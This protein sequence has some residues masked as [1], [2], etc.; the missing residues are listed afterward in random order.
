MSGH[1]YPNPTHLQTK[2]YMRICLYKGYVSVWCLWHAP[3]Q[4]PYKNNM[5]VV[6]VCLF[7]LHIPNTTTYLPTHPPTHPHTY[8]PTKHHHHHHLPTYLLN[9]GVCASILTFLLL[10]GVS[11]SIL[12]FSN[13]G[14][15]ASI[16]IFFKLG[17]LC[18]D[19]NIF[20][21]GGLCFDF[22]F[23]VVEGVSASI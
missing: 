2:T 14:A 19:Y 21:S 7:H 4:N 22:N 3:H 15:C 5:N 11:A 10:S 16:L 13:Q 12:T 1:T 18:F 20:N 9:C 23:F 17:A 6:F 8:Q